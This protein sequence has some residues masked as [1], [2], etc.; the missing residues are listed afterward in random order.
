MLHSTTWDLRIGER[1]ALLGRR[2]VRSGQTPVRF[3]SVPFITM[4]FFIGT[5]LLESRQTGLHDPLSFL[6][7]GI[8]LTEIQIN[9]T[10]LLDSMIH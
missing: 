3:R 2:Y 4:N 9:G 6:A 10:D 7:N 5:D 1:P 8:F